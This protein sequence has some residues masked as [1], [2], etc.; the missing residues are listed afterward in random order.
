MRSECDRIWSFGGDVTVVFVTQIL[1]GLLMVSGRL[2]PKPPQP[3]STNL[4]RCSDKYLGL[5]EYRA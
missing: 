2:P 1:R 5:L 3:P 4:A